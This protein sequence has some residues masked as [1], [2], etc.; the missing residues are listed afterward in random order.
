VQVTACYEQT[1]SRDKIEDTSP[2]LGRQRLVDVVL[3]RY[4]RARDLDLG[5]MHGVAP[6]Q[7]RLARRV[8]AVTRVPRCVPRQCDQRQPWGNRA[9]S[10]WAKL[11]AIVAAKRDISVIPKLAT[12]YFWKRANVLRCRRH[13]TGYSLREDKEVD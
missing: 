4:L 6:N 13:R 5:H 2:A 8:Q 9:R 7:Q 1:F 12:L 10:A 11:I 3:A